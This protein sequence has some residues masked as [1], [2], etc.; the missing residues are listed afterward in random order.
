MFIN[1]VSLIKNI[2][3]LTLIRVWHVSII[4]HLDTNSLFAYNLYIP[5]PITDMLLFVLM[6]G[7][8]LPYWKLHKKQAWIIFFFRHKNYFS[9]PTNP[10]PD[11]SQDVKVVMWRWTSIDKISLPDKWMKEDFQL[12]WTSALNKDIIYIFFRLLTTIQ[13]NLRRWQTLLHRKYHA[14]IS[15]WLG[16]LA[17]E[18]HPVWTHLLPLFQEV[19]KSKIF[20]ECL[21]DRAGRE[22]PR[23]GYC[24]KNFWK[25]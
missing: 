1:T 8:A 12:D 15:S 13:T 25:L 2:F 16:K 11:C 7:E 6:R 10:F 17:L 3:L 24:K 14:L 19:K 9:K 22:V 21:Q 4:D 18:N 20:T 23:K 5:Q